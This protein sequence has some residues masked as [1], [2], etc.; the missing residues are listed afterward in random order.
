MTL[1]IR[2]MREEDI[3]FVQEIAK[4][5]WHDTYEGI[6]PK[7]VQERFLQIAYSKE[8]LLKRRQKSSFLVAVLDES[9][10]GFANFSKT[11]NGQAELFAIYLVPNMQHKGIGTALLENGIQQL[12]NLT[13]LTV[14]VEKENTIA[15][16]FYQAKGFQ[17]VE[18]FDDLFDGH[19]LKTIRMALLFPR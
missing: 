7:K 10:V 19:V 9:L 18:E 6:I 15:M 12:E 17:F 4:S 5:S 14:C 2:Q 8:S 1:I 11:N 3:F 16:R 13:T